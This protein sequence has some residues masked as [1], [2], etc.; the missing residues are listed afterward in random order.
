MGKYEADTRKATI[1]L[2]EY[3]GRENIPP[4][5]TITRSFLLRYG[6]GRRKVESLLK[7]AFPEFE[8]KEDK[9]LR[10]E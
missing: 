3:L 6:F 9:I 8:I 2:Q 10:K 1:D 7:D 4:V 5:S